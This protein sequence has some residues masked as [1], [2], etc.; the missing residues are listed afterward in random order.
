MKGQNVKKSEVSES[1]QIL[2]G[3]MQDVGY[4]RI[5][6]L[7]ISGGNIFLT[8][9]SIWER[10]V[11]FGRNEDKLQYPGN[12]DYELKKQIADFFRYISDVDEGEIS[13]LEIQAGLPC[14]MRERRK[15]A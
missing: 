2:I 1:G 3:I 5:M 12:R 6:N 15:I 14:L 4:G 11:R 7:K 9:D 10:D 13:R 8:E